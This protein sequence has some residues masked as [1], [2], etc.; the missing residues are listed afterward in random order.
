MREILL[1]FAVAT[2]VGLTG[3]GAGSITAPMLILFLGLAPADS[4]GTA[5][6]FSAAVKM[7]AAPIYVCRKQVSVRT[8]L[9]LL[10]GG[11]PGVVAGFWM[12]GRL[13]AAR[14]QATLF[15]LLG[16]AVVIMSVYTFY[17]TV[18]RSGEVSGRDRW[19]WLPLMGAGVGAEVGFASAGA[20]ALGSLGLLRLTTLSPAQIVGTDVLFGL[21]LS[22]IGGGLHLA[23]G[24]YDGAILWRLIA[25]GLAG[26]LTGA[27]LTT[28]LP[29]RPLR[30][31]LAAWLTAVGAQLCWRALG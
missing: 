16:A 30:I 18:R 6:V 29:P 10:G 1:G 3:V 4:V 25:G 8:L 28:I 2:M 9:L 12:I 15:L 7:A 27:N 21:V 26:V 13:D 14:H 23:V 11:V 5:L 20:G 19:R 17:R 24:H 22:V 31:A